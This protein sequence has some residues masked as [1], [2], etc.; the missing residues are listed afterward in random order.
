MLMRRCMLCMGGSRSEFRAIF[1]DHL[2]S[3]FEQIY[4]DAFHAWFVKART[5][6]CKICSSIHAMLFGVDSLKLRGV[7]RHI[8][9]IA[10]Q[11][12]YHA[13]ADK[14]TTY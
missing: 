1:F 2:D 3:I 14:T 12:A 6:S 4:D 10:N 7:S 13:A 11:G 8:P 9:L 5:S